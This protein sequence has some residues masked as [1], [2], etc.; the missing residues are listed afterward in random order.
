MKKLAFI[1]M[2]AAL[3]SARFAAQYS[4]LGIITAATP[5]GSPSTVDAVSGVK[6]IKT[7]PSDV[8]VT[9]TATGSLADLSPRVQSAA[10]SG[11]VDTRLMTS[12]AIAGAPVDVRRL[13]AT[14]IIR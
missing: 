5:S 8:S 12:V 7:V 4:K 11:T 3:C 10:V 13:G 6:L 14:L 9:A 2:V 1:F